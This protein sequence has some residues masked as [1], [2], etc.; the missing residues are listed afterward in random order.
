MSSASQ[1]NRDFYQG[2]RVLLTGHTGFK[3]AWLT[4]V[5]HALGAQTAGYALPAIQGSLFEKIRGESLLAHHVGDIRDKQAIYDVVTQYQPEIV[6]HLAALATVQD[7]F[8]SPVD[9]YST[10]VLGTVY[11]LDALRVCSSVKSIVIVTTDKVYENKG[12]GACYRESDRL[13]GDDPY[14][15]SKACMEHV[16]HAYLRSY[17]QTN[18][19][20]TGI[21]TVRASNVLGGGDHVP[22]RL[23]PSILNAIH[24]QRPVEL[25]NPHQTRPWQSVLDALNGYL[26]IGR[27]L[28]DEPEAFSACWNI[29]PTQDGIREVE[30][31]AKRMQTHFHTQFGF[32][33]PAATKGVK[34]SETLGLDITKSLSKLGWQP[35][36]H[37]DEMLSQVVN[38]FRGQLAGTEERELCLDQVNTFFGLSPLS[39]KE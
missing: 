38:F 12:D 21:A 32:H 35:E 7:C 23:I 14:S 27:K 1:L 18:G 15:S 3:G 20:N 24:E 28:F 13:G 30:W 6:I 36:M 31:V 29:G 11:L 2:K 22:T 25:R 5:L 37:C 26:T 17:F 10:N 33:A 16:S 4:T 19:R 9:A 8:S 34:E 39:S